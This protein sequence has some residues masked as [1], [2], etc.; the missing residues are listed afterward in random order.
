MD[1]SKALLEKIGSSLDRANTRE[2]RARPKSTAAAKSAT[3]PATIATGRR[4]GKI[5]VSLF[6]ADFQRIEA[7]RGYLAQ[8][9]TIISRS[10]AVKVA[11]RSVTLG[12]D[13]RRALDEARREDGRK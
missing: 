8:R 12:D 4:A 7:I 5:S 10:E 3:P 11:L 6:E 13:L 2:A 9:G 1:K